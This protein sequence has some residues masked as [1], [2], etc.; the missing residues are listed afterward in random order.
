MVPAR[1]DG[2]MSSI[3]AVF[4]GTFDPVTN[5]HLDIIR[6]GAVL[7]GQIVVLVA[8][9]GR[10]TV[11]SSDERSSMVQAE[12]DDLENVSVEGFDGLL[13]NEARRHGAT[14]LLRGVRGARDWDYEMQMAFANRGMAP[15]VE[16][17]FLPPTSG[18]TQISGTLVR[19]VA[20]LGGDVSAWV[21]KTVA[22][23]LAARLS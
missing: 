13:I 9:D 1:Y 6:R 21:P 17:V 15:D 4:A 3:T 8:K 10:K 11:F 14:V 18:M 2:P 20:S 12:L 19:E 16:T 5:G 7:F 23:A 22:E